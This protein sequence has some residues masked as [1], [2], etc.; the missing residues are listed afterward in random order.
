MSFIKSIFA[1]LLTILIAGF[2]IINAQSIEVSWSPIHDALSLPLYALI[3]GALTFG[4]IIGAVSVWLNS[5]TLRKTKRQQKKQIK[6]LEKELAKTTP[7][8]PNQKP[9]EDFFPAL[10]HKTGS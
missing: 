2:C 9:L 3:L 1:F 6:N 7:S 4:F 5:S 10:T 8:A